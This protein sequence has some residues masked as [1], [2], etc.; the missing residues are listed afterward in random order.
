MKLKISNIK[1]DLRQPRELREAAA[2]KLGLGPDELSIEAVLRRAVDARKKENICLNYQVLAKI[3][4]GKNFPR[5]FLNKRDV[6]LYHE[7]VEEQL[8]LGKLPLKGPVI[9]IGAGPAGLLGA[10]ELA[11]HG[12]A[13]LI[14]ERGQALAQRVKSV[15]KFWQDG[16]LDPES[17][18]QFGAG[19]AGTFSDG[20]L[21]TRVDDPA[22]SAIAR[23]LVAAGAPANILYEYRPHV[24]TDKLRLMVGGLIRRIK[25]LGGQVRYQT[26]VK[27]FL[28]DNGKLTGLVLADGQKV[29]A[30]AVLLACGHSARDTYAA[31][32]RRQIAMEMKP[33]AVGLRIEHPQDLIDRA[34]Y[35]GFAGHPLLGAAAYQLVHH[36]VEG[37]TCYSFCMCPGGCVVAA[38]SERGGVAVNGMSDF[39]RDSGVA[40]SA[41]VVNVGPRDFPA[42]AMGGV[43]FQRYWEE[44]AFRLGGGNYRAPAQNLDTFL[45]GTAPSLQGA[46]PGSYRPGLKAAELERALPAF[47]INSIRE[48][49]A[50]F[51]KKVAGFA[52]G[53]A[54]LTGVES[55]TSA[56]LRLLRNK[57]NY[58]SCNCDLLYPCGE[59]AGYAGGIMSAALDG[60]RAARALMSRF[61][62]PL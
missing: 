8:V 9:V 59:G 16:D 18:A 23:T 20:K 3:D 36:G 1:I 13:P 17:N 14:L 15:E 49:V 62:P 34:Q 37:R 31:L 61:A 57:E 29:A 56:P 26:K 43:A 4:A 12:Y 19:G 46:V 41:L 22:L 47:V 38:A 50:A 10:L 60:Y 40:N 6:S 48:A 30:G 28:V 53:G 58:V 55:R 35:G 5:R 27:D 7:P 45:K 32:A 21:T 25:E 51:D 52:D 2:K 39:A 54:L 24:G 42:G 44:T 33:F 11:E